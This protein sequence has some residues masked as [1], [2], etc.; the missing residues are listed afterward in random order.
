MLHQVRDHLVQKALPLV[1]VVHRKAA[2][3]T[4]KGAAGGHQLVVLIKQAAGVVQ[5]AVQGDSLPLQQ[6]AELSLSPLV[7]GVDLTEGI[8]HR[9]LLL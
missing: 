1:A 3:G 2:Q 6:G 5:I 8:G 4:P 7:V 9:G